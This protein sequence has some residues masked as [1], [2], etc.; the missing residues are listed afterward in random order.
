MSKKFNGLEEKQFQKLAGLFE[1][2]LSFSDRTY[3]ENLTLL[4]HSIKK[5]IVEVLDNS[6]NMTP[7]LKNNYL[8]VLKQKL[9][10][11]RIKY[12]RE[13]LE[14]KLKKY[15]V[16]ESSFP[17]FHNDQLNLLLNTAP[18]KAVA[19]LSSKALARHSLI[20]QL[21]ECF[22]RFWMAKRKEDLKKQ[23][24]DILN[25]P[26]TDEEGAEEPNE[27]GLFLIH[28]I[29]IGYMDGTLVPAEDLYGKN[30]ARVLG[31]K[32]KRPVNKIA[33]CLKKF[34]D[35]ASEYRKSETYKRDQKIAEAFIAK[36][37]DDSN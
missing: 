13:V 26:V 10:A 4:E 27:G 37:R 23:L 20:L 9:D 17:E 33:G 18:S 6:L 22:F 24:E 1:C 14:H 28:Q 16:E 29:H 5:F 30:L 11:I 35:P 12:D 2:K 7:E 36:Y 19:G 3:Y 34:N 15:Q 32:W 25:A 31:K 8:L 21:Q